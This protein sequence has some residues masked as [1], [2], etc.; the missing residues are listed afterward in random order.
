MTSCFARKARF[1]LIAAFPVVLGASVPVADGTT[2]EFVVKSQSTQTGNKETVTMRGRSTFA[3]D[4]ARVEILSNSV[5]G[6]EGMFGGKGSYFLVLD[7]GQKMLLVDPSQRSYMS[8]DMARMFAGMGKA[9]N[10][11][12]GLVKM[13]MS[14]IR[15]DAQDMGAGETIQGYSTRHVRMIQNYTV[16]AK[17]F[18]RTSTT[19]TET[20]TDYHF[21]PALAKMTNPFVSNSQTMAMMSQL[22]MFNNPDYQ[23]QMAAANAKLQRGVP[24]KMV[25]RT[26]STDSKG[27]QDVSVV[28]TEM[29][30]FS[31]ANVPKSTFAIPSGYAQ[32]EMP[33]MGAAL[34]G[35]AGANA[36]P[37]FNADSVVG[38]A[39]QGIKEG[40]KEGVKEGAKE[41]TKAKLRGIFKR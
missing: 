13:Q 30:N 33:N 20:T 28:T 1:A 9:V 31:K 26:V 19:R 10:A 40:L 38:D 37:G 3:G 34:A 17:M 32:V 22:D 39:K 14:D 12:G 11:I 23:R 4:D 8:W 6:A 27:K 2:Y 35:G 5:A 25:A 7:G 15:I 16:S 18:G 36:K 24:L 41:A 21:A 29:V